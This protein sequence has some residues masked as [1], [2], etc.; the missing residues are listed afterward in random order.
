MGALETLRRRERTIAAVRWTIAG[1]LLAQVALGRASRPGA[2]LVILGVLVAQGIAV[3]LGEDH[4]QTRAAQQ[5]ATGLMMGLDG[6]LAVAYAV[7][8]AGAG[9]DL[10]WVAFVLISMEGALRYRLRGALLTA[11]AASATYVLIEAATAGL[12]AAVLDRVALILLLG[13]AAGAIA[14][15]LDAERQVFERSSRRLERLEVLRTRFVATVAHDLRSPLTTVKGVASILRDR[16]D[17]VSPQRVD[18]MLESV[19]RQANR[20]NRLADDLL[21]AARLD[22][23]QLELNCGAVDVA[24]VV[25]SVA[26][27]APDDVEVQVQAGIDLVADGPRLERIVWNL[28]SNAFKY[29]RS[30]VVVS[31][32][33]DPVE[34]DVQIRVRDHG[35][36]LSPEQVTTLFTEFAAGNDPSSVGLGLAIVWELVQAHG[37]RV[38]YA[39]GDPGALFIVTLP[40]R[41]CS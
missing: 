38:T 4:L 39:D 13:G 15:E 37:G 27:D 1:L 17:T 2:V 24:A 7:Q 32:A 10:A 8:V 19:E 11:A 12:G 18:A 28:V 30:P 33:Q 34:G 26:A 23:D 22:S 20:L 5:R 41:P 36:G 31:A 25:T 6:V 9:R 3:R 40:M 21:D 35:R 14:F 29:G 16:R